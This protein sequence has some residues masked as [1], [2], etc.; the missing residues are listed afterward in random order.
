[1][2]SMANCRTVLMPLFVFAGPLGAVVA[3]LTLQLPDWGDAGQM[4]VPIIGRSRG[5]FA[6]TRHGAVTP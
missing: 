5:I 4:V 1:M 3:G 6:P 2:P